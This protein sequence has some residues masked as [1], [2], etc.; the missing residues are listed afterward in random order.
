VIR[1]KA[2]SKNRE[3][4]R[5]ENELYSIM[6]QHQI[7]HYDK[8]LRYKGDQ[9]EKKKGKLQ[10]VGGVFGDIIGVIISE[11]VRIFGKLVSDVAREVTAHG[12]VSIFKQFTDITGISLNANNFI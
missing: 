3:S 10:T 9:E 8:E 4:I 5:K 11:V 2:D 6:Q 1:K 12:F 7:N